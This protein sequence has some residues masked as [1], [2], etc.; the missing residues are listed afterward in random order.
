MYPEL[1]T[2]FSEFVFVKCP[3]SEA[4]SGSRHR[5]DRS[6]RKGGK[7]Q[8]ILETGIRDQLSG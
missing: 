5:V 3:E 2:L 8:S 7:G 4:E 6:R 1:I